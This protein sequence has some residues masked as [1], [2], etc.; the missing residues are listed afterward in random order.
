[1]VSNTWKIAGIDLKVPMDIVIL[2]LVKQCAHLVPELSRQQK[3][4]F[5]LKATLAKR[6][7]RAHSLF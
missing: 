2:L 3:G 4:I 1:M 6:L 5:R 7:L